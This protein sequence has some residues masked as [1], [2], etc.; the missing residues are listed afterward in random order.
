MNCFVFLF[1]CLVIFFL[2]EI[3]NWLCTIV[4]AVYIDYYVSLKIARHALCKDL[5]F[6]FKIKSY[7]VFTSLAFL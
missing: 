1:D 5:I 3:S 6:T 2:G 7:L 4:I